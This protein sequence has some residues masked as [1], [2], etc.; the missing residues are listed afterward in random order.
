MKFKNGG[1]FIPRWYLL[2]VALMSAFIG[3]MAGLPLGG[4]AVA[5]AILDSPADH[6]ARTGRDKQAWVDQYRR[7]A[8]L[9]RITR[10]THGK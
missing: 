7:D 10:R 1:R 9:H 6:F 4:Y 2:R 8:A 5:W 3:T